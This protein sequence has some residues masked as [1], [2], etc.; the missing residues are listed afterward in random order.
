MSIIHALKVGQVQYILSI[1]EPRPRAALGSILGDIWRLTPA[2]QG[3]E[4]WLATPSDEGYAT[5]SPDGLWVAYASDDSGRPEIYVRA[6]SGSGGR[7]PV[8]T[9][10]GGWPRWS[11]GGREIFFLREG[12]LWSAAVKTAP[13]F[14]S[15]PPRKLFDVPDEILLEAYYEVS[16]DDQRFVMIGC[17]S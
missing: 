1:H 8:S 5:F 7:H 13:E 3:A 4:P 12:S 10:G 16:P 14:A 15:D 6:Y 2:D 11:G 17:A 9:E